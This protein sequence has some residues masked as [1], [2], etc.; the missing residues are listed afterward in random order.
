MFDF[1]ES[2]E[3]GVPAGGAETIA[4]AERIFSG[5]DAWLRKF[6]RM[7]SRPQQTNM[8]LAA[9]RAFA[10]DSALLF[11]AGTGVGKSLAYLLPG[12]IFSRQIGRAHV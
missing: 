1:N 8:A 11:E 3:T 4:F 10:D 9:A 7:E 12:L 5:G 2:F 6:L